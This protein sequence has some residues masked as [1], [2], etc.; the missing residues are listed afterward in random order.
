MFSRFIAE[1]RKFAL[2]AA[3]LFLFFAAFNNYQDSRVWSARGA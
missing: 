2:V 3:F 1:M